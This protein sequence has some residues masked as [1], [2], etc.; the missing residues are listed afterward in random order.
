MVFTLCAY[1]Q[2]GYAFGRVGLCMYVC[3][4]IYVCVYIC[5]QKN[6]LFSALLLENLLLSVMNCLL[7]K[8]KCLQCDLLCLASCIQTE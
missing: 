8:F 7:F 1:A 2:Q 4:Y 6:G 3:I 5:G